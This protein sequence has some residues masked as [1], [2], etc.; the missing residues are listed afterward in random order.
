MIRLLF[1]S[2]TFYALENDNEEVITYGTRVS[3][4]L[5]YRTH[6]VIDL[7]GS[8]LLFVS[9]VGLHHIATEMLLQYLSGKALGVPPGGI[10][11]YLLRHTLDVSVLVKRNKQSK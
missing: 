11:I 7:Y 2:V 6:R 3:A 1:N 9:C 8:T 5:L 10:D 4:P